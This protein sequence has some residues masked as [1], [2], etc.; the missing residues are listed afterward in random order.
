MIVPRCNAQQMNMG[1]LLLACRNSAMMVL[2]ELPER[3]DAAGIRE[4]LETIC[5][6]LDHCSEKMIETYPAEKQPTMQNLRESL[7]I[8][9]TAKYKAVGVGYTSCRTDT[10][11][12]LVKE[13][14][15]NCKICIKP[16]KC[17]KCD[18]G[19]AL[20][21]CTPEERNKGESWADIWI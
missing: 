15:E 16:D 5:I 3:V 7:C 21:R 14:H 4:M 8:E 18:L 9:L 17:N 11:D 20:D 1:L 2:N 13:A 6:Q 19:K 10:F 12:T